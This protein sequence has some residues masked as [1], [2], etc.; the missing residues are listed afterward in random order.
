[1]RRFL[2]PISHRLTLWNTLIVALLLGGFAL[3]VAWWMQAATLAGISRNVQADLSAAALQWQA[4][5]EVL[6]AAD[7][8]VLQVIDDQGRIRAVSGTWPAGLGLPGPQQSAAALQTRPDDDAIYATGSLGLPD[9]L[10]LVAVLEVS[11]IVG[12]LTNLWEILSWVTVAGVVLAAGAGYLMARLALRPVDA[13]ART[14]RQVGREARQV[15]HEALGVGQ[16]A[17]LG[18]RMSRMP[19]PAA[20]DEL[21]RLAETFNDMLDQVEAALDSQT[22][23]VSDA[24]HELRT[25]V[26]VISGYANLLRRWG[27]TDAA[28][29]DEAVAAIVRESE[30]MSS[31]LRNLL[32]IA[33]GERLQAHR[34]PIWLAPLLTSVCREGEILASTYGGSRTS[35]PVTDGVSL[36]FQV[37]CPEDLTALA[38]APY[39]QQSLLALVD[40]AVRHT[41]AGGQV[42]ISARQEEGAVWISIADTG[43]GIPP[44]HLPHIFERFYRVDP[45]RS[46]GTGGAG[47]GLA[48]ARW[49]VELQGGSI[50]VSS[51]VA[52]GTAFQIRLPIGLQA[53]GLHAPNPPK[54]LA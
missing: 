52:G 12:R 3:T 10:R 27:S 49:L 13:M 20:K 15:G 37:D 19:L 18:R 28:V 33:R 17:R 41:P 24:S 43:T 14:A 44:E 5:R 25:P 48:I 16:E 23:F 46:R 47:L 36:Q 42:S 54:L 21:H 22:R 40:N 6:P 51:Q 26:T 4:S 34:E 50:G 31:L 38:D 11:D 7:G 35:R 45:D 9:G 29:R 1:M 30:R 2:Q 39:L 53:P 8:A 32:L